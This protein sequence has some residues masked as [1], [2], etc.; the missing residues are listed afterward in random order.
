MD[1]DLFKLD[2]GVREIGY[3]LLAGVLLALYVA[4]AL[5]KKPA[6]D[7]ESLRRELLGRHLSLSAMALLG[8]TS[9]VGI[10]C[11]AS[12]K[13]MDY[14]FREGGVFEAISAGSFFSVLL[15]AGIYWIFLGDRSVVNTGLLLLGLG[16]FLDEISY[17]MRLFEFRAPVMGKIHIDGIHDVLEW[18]YRGESIAGLDSPAVLITALITV[19]GGV[20]LGAWWKR[21]WIVRAI[22]ECL[23]SPA[24]WYAPWILA[25]GFVS[26][27]IDFGAWRMPFG[28]VRNIGPYVE[29]ALEMSTAL[30]LCY[31][32]YANGR[33]RQYQQS[34]NDSGAMPSPGIDETPARYAA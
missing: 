4:R 5:V 22:G 14:A 16:G 11:L 33:S 8:V 9:A 7:D 10:A 30:A 32:W 17:G 31:A 34:Q 20:L 26:C 3:T 21:D 13:I 27:A 29:E 6:A 18:M 2:D 1:A 24:L 23:A 19:A 25:F 12:P 28:G 15:L